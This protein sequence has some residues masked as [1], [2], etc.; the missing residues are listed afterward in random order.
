MSDANSGGQSRYD[1]KRSWEVVPT[2][3]QNRTSFTK[4]ALGGF[5]R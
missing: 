4:A 1:L 5:Y 2:T 3:E